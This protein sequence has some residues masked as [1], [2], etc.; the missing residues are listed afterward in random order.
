MIK[1]SGVVLKPGDRVLVRNLGERGGHGKLRSYWEKKVYIVK[2]QVSDNPV[3]VIHSEG[4][5]NARHRTLHRNVL[6][7]VNDLPIESPAQPANSVP[8][9]PQ[10][11]K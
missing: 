2:E 7:L 10:T 9:H 3:V 4:E 1:E 11:Q 8:R 5:P 6:L